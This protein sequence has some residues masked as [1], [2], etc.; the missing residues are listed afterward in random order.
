MKLVEISKNYSLSIRKTKPII[1]VT[2]K[3][4][5]WFT[6]TLAD[7]LN[8]EE[9]TIISFFQDEEKKNDFYIKRGGNIK[10]HRKNE[11]AYCGHA[12]TTR[13]LYK[14]LGLDENKNYSFFVCL[15]PREYNGELYHAIITSKPI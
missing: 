12:Q 3:G 5:I 1:H 13:I 10:I 9:G 7:E 4:A 15:E 2:Y 6:K 14:Q 11:Y 8:F